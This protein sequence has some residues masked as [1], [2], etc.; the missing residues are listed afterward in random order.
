M[1]PGGRYVYLM[2]RRL[3]ERHPARFHAIVTPIERRDQPMRG[4]VHDISTSGIC[5]ILP[6]QLAPGDQV[7]LEMADSL[8][9]GH[10]IFC[11]QESGE[12][13]TG[14]EVERVLLGDTDLSHVL[15]SVLVTHLPALVL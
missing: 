9:F 3:A 10:V 12:F 15:Q 6:L 13:R 4:L 14:I 2:D 1:I 5:A 11:N 7:K 8:L